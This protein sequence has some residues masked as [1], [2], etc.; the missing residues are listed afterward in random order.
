[1][2]DATGLLQQ[3]SARLS[4]AGGERPVFASASAELSWLLLDL[5]GRGARRQEAEL[6]LQAAALAHQA[7]ALDLTLTV[8]LAWFS[9]QA[10]RALAEASAVGVQQA[11]ASLDAAEARRR[12]GA[13]TVADV[14]QARTARSQA[15]LDALRLDGQVLALRG[16]LATLAGLPPSTPLEVVPLPAELPPDLALPAVERLLEDAASTNPELARA[17]AQA[18]AAEARATAAARANLPTLS[19]AATAGRAWP[20][21]PSGAALQA[22]TAGLVLSVPLLDGGRSRFDAEAS[23][24]VARAARERAE[25]AARRTGLET[26]TSLQALRTSARRIETSRDLLA[27]ASAGAEVAAA[28]YQ[29]GVGSILDL[30]A[31]QSALA[32]ARAEEIL[33]RADWLVAVARL[34]RATGRTPPAAH[35]AL[36]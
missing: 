23:R 20:L 7:A 22:W 2:L 32:G 36:R 30:L 21:E 29:E 24:E 17:R 14:L 18:G 31:A 3:Q 12:A 19:L 4:D 16:T 11:T 9:Y 8:E 13:A 34:A 6:E 27:S 33:A 25:Q 1:M 28:R 10:A 5:G 26:W 35:G 15:T